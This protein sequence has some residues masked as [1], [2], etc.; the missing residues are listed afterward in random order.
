MAQLESITNEISLDS[1]PFLTKTLLSTTRVMLF[2]SWI[3]LVVFGCHYNNE[4]SRINFLASSLTGDIFY[5][6]DISCVQPGLIGFI[7]REEYHGT[8]ETGEIV[9]FRLD[10]EEQLTQLLSTSLSPPHNNPKVIV[11]MDSVLYKTFSERPGAEPLIGLELVNRQSKETTVVHKDA[12]VIPSS[13]FMPRF[14]YQPGDDLVFFQTADFTLR[15]WN[16]RTESCTQII[17][18]ARLIGQGF[19]KDELCEAIVLLDGNVMI[20]DPM[21]SLF[22]DAPRMQWMSKLAA[23]WDPNEGHIRGFIFSS[24]LA[25]ANGKDKESLAVIDRLGNY[26]PI[27]VRS[28]A[29][30]HPS[31]R[32]RSDWGYL[33]ESLKPLPFKEE[34]KKASPD[35]VG[36]LNFIAIDSD[37]IGIFD[38]SY[39]RLVVIAEGY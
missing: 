28:A 1:N 37:R 7:T 20:Y 38:S 32:R 15:L 24:S 3:I 21:Q 29:E 5:Q 12:S 33:K 35:V 8:R 17:E 9:I 27:T 22:V 23:Y 19:I 14:H 16:Q 18:N 6:E 34:G 2:F 4:H 13:R 26:R 11:D 25:M 10:N 36:S 31:G 39:Q 30:Y